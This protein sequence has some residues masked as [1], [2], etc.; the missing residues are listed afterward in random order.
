MVFLSTRTCGIIALKVRV[1]I[2]ML[3]IN[4]PSLK[5][6]NL[7][8]LEPTDICLLPKMS[9]SWWEVE[10][11]KQI[12]LGK[13]KCYILEYIGTVGILQVNFVSTKQDKVNI[14]NEL[15]NEFSYKLHFSVI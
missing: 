15:F 13:F 2:L 3:M 10:S 14:L 1:S 5:A 9:A 4:Q 6:R 8:L 12:L 7:W 11:S